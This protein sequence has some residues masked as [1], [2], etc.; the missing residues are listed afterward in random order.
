[1]KLVLH[2]VWKDCRRLRWPLA[3]W[4]FLVALKIGIGFS[5]ILTGG[6]AGLS[7]S[8]LQDVT[9]ELA[10]VAS[11]LTIV[12]TAMLVQED[13]LVGTTQFW[14]TRPISR[15]RLL[16][17]KLAGWVLLLYLP[18]VVLSLPW[19]LTCAFGPREIARAALD[20]LALQVLVSVPAALVASLTDT[21]SRFLVW[22]L[23][24]VFAG[25]VLPSM[26]MLWI[27]G[28]IGISDAPGPA[29]ALFIWAT[30]GLVFAA[31]IVGQ[32]LRRDVVRSLVRLAV[33]SVLAPVMAVLANIALAPLFS[34]QR[35]WTDWHPE[36]MEGVTVSL[37]G[38][39]ASASGRPP[40]SE[41]YLE[42]DFAVQ[43]LPREMTLD[44]GT[45]LPAQQTWRW[46]GGPVLK[47]D[48]T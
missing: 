16:V 7:A 27:A 15:W 40:G 35:T 31:V 46:P 36:R 41:I 47:R 28:W 14:L 22:G 10:G 33:G 44:S 20:L 19:W 5:L 30:V 25:A 2:I 3:L 21:L 17:A 42:T 37:N 12:L 11:L 34:P 32:F 18:A 13:S 8:R 38:F 4:L 29:F 23:V 1:M 6:F 45:E 24:L 39:R 48:S 9:T 43:G 26:L